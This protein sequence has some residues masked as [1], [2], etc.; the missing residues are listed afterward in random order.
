MKNFWVFLLILAALVLFGYAL[1]ASDFPKITDAKK[2]AIRDAQVKLLSL[3]VQYAKLPQQIQ[4]ASQA[5]A[6]LVN[7][8]KPKDCTSC[9]F[10]EQQLEWVK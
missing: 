10:D 1:R 4:E 8:E 6:K 3:Q 5:Y 7:D 2:L 9:S